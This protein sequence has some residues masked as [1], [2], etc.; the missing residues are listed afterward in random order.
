MVKICGK[1]FKNLPIIYSRMSVIMDDD[2]II[3]LDGPRS[4]IVFAYDDID[5]SDDDDE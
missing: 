2:E 3:V 1:V 4:I 5:D